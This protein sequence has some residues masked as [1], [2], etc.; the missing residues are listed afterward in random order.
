MDRLRI[1]ICDD[2]AIWRERVRQLC[3]KY[4]SE[5]N[6]DFEIKM[7]S[8][9]DKIL[10]EKEPLTFLFLDEEMPEM[11]G[12]EVNKV[13]SKTSTEIIFVTSHSEIV[14][15]CFGRNVLGFLRKPI[16]EIEF[17]RII[18]KLLVDWADNLNFLT[19]YHSQELIHLPY[20]SIIYLKAEESYTKLFCQGNRNY[21]IRKNLNTLDEL[22]TPHNFIRIHKSYMI[23]GMYSYK[24]IKN[25]MLLETINGELLP[26]ARRRKKE[27]YTK[28]EQLS[29]KYAKRIWQDSSS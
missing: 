20:S 12:R 24:I 16:D 26:I 15:D 17:E 9:G 3:E 2:E 13:L 5:K 21:L 22:L 4:L 10:Q 23:N 1:G 8:S 11:T 28:S 19:F 7:F 29:I 27:V 14:Y 18:S 6:I 25:G